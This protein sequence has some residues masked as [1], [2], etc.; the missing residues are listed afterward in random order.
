MTEQEPVEAIRGTPA[1]AVVM[2]AY[3]GSAT[4]GD[5]IKSC[6][7]QT[8]PSLEL[9]VVDDCSTDDTYRIVQGIAQ[10]DPRVKV[11]QTSSNSG[12]PALPKTVGV[13][14]TT[15]PIVMFCDQDDRF[16]PE[17]LER[18]AEVFARYPDTDIVFTDYW[19]DRESGAV[20][21]VTY[22]G[23]TRNFTKVASAYLK[24][25]DEHIYQC[26]RFIGCMASGIDTG[27]ATI[28]IAIRKASLMR[29]DYVF[30]RRYRIVDDIDL[31]HRLALHANIKYLDSPLAV[32]NWSA[33]TLSGNRELYGLES[34]QFYRINYA[35]VQDLLTPGE[36]R[37]GRRMLAR[38]AY[39]LAVIYQDRLARCRELALESLRH[40]PNML[41]FKLLIECQSKAMRSWFD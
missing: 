30:T 39:E 29:E 24:K 4:I 31:W 28:N 22:L 16:L 14:H 20:P 5:S 34:L 32:Y 6:L 37:A 15:A 10:G 23:E 18:V 3:N 7:S 2:A 33:S 17:K 26:E 21:L 25:L 1:F 19:I 41:A 40:S 13:H 38:W 27:M 36:R 12:G 35:R 9:I 11:L 8:N